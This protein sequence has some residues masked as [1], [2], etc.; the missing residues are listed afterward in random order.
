[1]SGCETTDEYIRLLELAGFEGI[2]VA[3]PTGFST[4]PTT[5]GFD[6]VAVK[7]CSRLRPPPLLLT[8]GMA[9]AAAAAV[10]VVVL[11][12]RARRA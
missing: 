4:S 2:R 10:G 12:T 3:G 6:F 11:A 5:R 9:A 7:P 8:L 1:M